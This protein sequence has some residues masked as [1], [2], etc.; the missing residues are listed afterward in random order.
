MCLMEGWEK[1]RVDVISFG[2]L[3]VESSIAPTSICVFM[4]IF[5]R[6]MWY[7]KEAATT[8]PIP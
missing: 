7:E 8:D 4:S 2:Q 5:T 6:Y 3:H 1:R